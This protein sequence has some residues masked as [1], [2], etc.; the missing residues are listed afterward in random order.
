MTSLKNQRRDI[1]MIGQT[2]CAECGKIIK[3][4]DV[5]YSLDKTKMICQT[6]YDKDVNL[7]MVLKEK[8]TPEEFKKQYTQDFNRC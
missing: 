6:C 1:I 8:M 7:L 3:T 2:T 5:F 4:I